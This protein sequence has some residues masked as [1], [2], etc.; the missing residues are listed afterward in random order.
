MPF[1]ESGYPTKGDDLLFV[2]SCGEVALFGD[3]GE[4]K[5]LIVK[6]FKSKDRLSD[7]RRWSFENDRVLLGQVR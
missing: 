6:A 2:W 4:G 3:R 1:N 5:L 7:I